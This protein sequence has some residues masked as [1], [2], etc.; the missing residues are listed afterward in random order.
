MAK[1]DT[2]K[3]A[4]SRRYLKDAEW[5]I[6]RMLK[7]KRDYSD[8]YDFFITNEALEAK[9]SVAYA[10]WKLPPRVTEQTRDAIEG[11]TNI[12]GGITVAVGMMEDEQ[13]EALEVF[14][15]LI[16]EIEYVDEDILSI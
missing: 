8:D 9:A 2:A 6:K 5:R 16:G 12:I 15:D 7:E 14:Q 10:I 13:D 1:K 4:D 11:L 3:Y